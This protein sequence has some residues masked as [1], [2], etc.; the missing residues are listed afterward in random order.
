MSLDKLKLRS[1]GLKPDPDRVWMVASVGAHECGPLLPEEV[2]SL[3]LH[4]G[5]HAM[6]VWHMLRPSDVRLFSDIEPE[7]KLLVSPEKRQGPPRAHCQATVL[8]QL[9]NQ[10][11]I[12]AESI[13]LAA[14]GMLMRLDRGMLSVG[15]QLNLTAS[16]TLFLSSFTT[17]GRVARKVSELIY[18]VE[19]LEPSD[20][21]RRV[22]EAFLIMASNRDAA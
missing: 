4:G 17:R 13:D 15:S 9:R 11:I 19:F 21:V 3:G 18:A 8:L 1:I 20:E 12:H 16:H 7:L 14:N 10:S 6:Q 5:V 2:L 22:I